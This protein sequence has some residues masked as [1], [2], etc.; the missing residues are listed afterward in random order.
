MFENPCLAQSALVVKNPKRQII[1]VVGISTEI[2]GKF[3]D[4]FSTVTVSPRSPRP[5]LPSAEV[6]LGTDQR[7]SF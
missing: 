3:P 6:V 2:S 7:S 4:S 1:V 5:E